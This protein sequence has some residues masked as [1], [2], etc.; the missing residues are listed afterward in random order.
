[1]LNIT[2]VLFFKLILTVHSLKTSIQTED[3]VSLR[4]VESEILNII[5]TFLKMWYL[6]KNIFKY[7][8]RS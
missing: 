2:F 7:R 4:Y 5:S 8:I 3:N 1:M 6:T